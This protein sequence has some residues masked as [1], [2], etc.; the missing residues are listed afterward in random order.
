MYDLQASQGFDLRAGIPP[1][2]GHGQKPLCQQRGTDDLLLYGTAAK[3]S[4]TLS[5]SRREQIDQRYPARG[6]TARAGM[7]YCELRSR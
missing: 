5:S 1:L 7:D 2:P 3:E 6:T 4:S